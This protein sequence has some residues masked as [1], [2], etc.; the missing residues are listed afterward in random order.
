MAIDAKTIE[1]VAARL[2]GAAESGKP[3]PPIREELA[4]GGVE[5]AYAVQNI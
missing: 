1:G 3:I 4:A 2:R 5:A